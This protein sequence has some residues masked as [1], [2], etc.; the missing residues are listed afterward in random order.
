MTEHAVVIAGG[1]P[2]GLM[3]AAES[4]LVGADAVA[5]ARPGRR[6]VVNGGFVGPRESFAG[7]VCRLGGRAGVCRRFALG[8]PL[9]EFGPDNP[10]GRFLPKSPRNRRC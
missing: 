3:L 7:R 2:T 8:N 10:P 4:A 6:V 5:Q 1:G 9:R